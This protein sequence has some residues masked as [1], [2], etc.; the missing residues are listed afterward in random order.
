[1]KNV[2]LLHFLRTRPEIPPVA[3]KILFGLLNFVDRYSSGYFIV[4]RA[5][6]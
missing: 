3:D 6:E 5:C 2:R 4:G 1:M